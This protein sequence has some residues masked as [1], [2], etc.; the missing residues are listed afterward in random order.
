MIYLAAMSD[1]LNIVDFLL[2]I[3]RDIISNDAG[4][5]DGQI[6]KVIEV[7]EE[8]FPDLDEAHIVLVG[9]GEQRGNGLRTASAAADEIRKEFF[10][11]FYWHTDIKLA[12]V[13]NIK[14]SNSLPDTRQIEC[15]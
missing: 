14:T 10:Q 9:C 12:D 13:G 7:Y 11:L 4:Y 15:F 8:G 2:T 6:G 3:D 5:K 1:Y